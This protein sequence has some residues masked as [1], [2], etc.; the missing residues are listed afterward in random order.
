MTLQMP[1]RVPLEMPPGDADAMAALARDVGAAGRC[2]AAIDARISDAADAAP[3]W[4]GDDA[5]AAAAQVGR[6]DDLIRA[7]YD[8]VA[9]GADRLA[10]HAEL[11]LDTRRRV[12]ALR[13]EQDEDFV[14][15]WRRWGSLPDLEL[16]VMVAGAEASAIV[17]ELEARERSRRSRHSALLAETEDDTAATSRALVDACAAVGG[18]GLPGDDSSVV[19]Y[20]AGRLPGWGD[21]ELARRGRALAA[22]Y[23]TVLT[24]DERESL[25]RDVLPFAGSA[26]FAEAMLA[27]LGVTGMRFALEV[28]GDGFLGPDSAFAQVMAQALGAAASTSSTAAREV[29]DTEYVPPATV[30]GR[31]DLAVLGMG[32]L[33]A[34]SLRLGSRGVAAG[35]VVSWG[36]Q[37]ALRDRLLGGT[38]AERAAAVAGSARP[39]DPLAMVVAD[40]AGLRD[41]EAGASFLDGSAVWTVLLARP[42]SD[43]GTSLGQL[44]RT[45]AADPGPAGDRAV[46]GGLEAL[47]A[48]LEDGDAHDWPVDPETVRAL[49]PALADALAAHVTV[50]GVALSAS[51][52][53][54]LTPSDAAM[55]RG[56]GS[57]T[58]DGQAA[59]VVAGALDR[60][61][62]AQPVPDWRTGP[63][64]AFP[65][66]AVPNA[67]LAVRQ[68]G[69]QLSR[70]LQEIDLQRKAADRAFLWNATV[71][72]AVQLAPGPW[73]RVGGVVADYVAMWTDMDGTWVAG[74]DRARTFRPDVPPAEALQSLTPEEFDRVNTLADQAKTS[75]TRTASSLGVVD[76]PVSAAKNW[77]GPIEAALTVGPGDVLDVAT[78]IHGHVPPIR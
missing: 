55:L 35:T 78:H 9:R 59:A 18:H 60:W 19:A 57:V 13:H 52:E 62:G 44:I 17:H 11:V 43:G 36:R 47:G 53:H 45:A 27:G 58:L 20:L 46:R 24:G 77:W 21:M 75:F 42:W 54:P 71:G 41:A 72:L 15:A 39:V 23:A 73:G 69:Q 2:L 68:Y 25:S 10:R 49:S 6:V 63:P 26:A 16:Q 67:Y 1:E 22:K 8:A 66:I 12:R 33:L 74:P 29:L 14:G 61:V 34:T 7:A 31:V 30:D 64:P 65:A 70:A 76:V 51:A 5:S 3:G 40:L 32:T 37:I 28:L 4:L 56:L 48:H 50:A 38:A